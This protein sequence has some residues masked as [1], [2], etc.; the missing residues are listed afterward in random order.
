MAQQYQDMYSNYNSDRSP[1]STRTYGNL[2]LNR[3]SS[4]QFDNY[5]SAQMQQNQLQG[6]YT[7]DDYAAQQHSGPPP[8]FEQRMPASTMHNNGYSPYENQTW[9][10][11]GQS[12]V[13]N[14]MSQTSRVKATRSRA[15]IPS[16]WLP[17]GQQQQLSQ[18]QVSNP[19]GSM[20]QY[21]SQLQGQNRSPPLSA[22]EE[23]IPTA[24]VIKNIP[25]AVKKEQLV[26]LMTDMGLPLPYA[27]NYH[28][29]AGVFRG[30]AFAN[31][32]N[33]DETSTVIQR[34]NHMDLHGRKLRVEYKKML[35][36]QER[37]RI[38]R[39]KREKRGQLQEQ[40]QPLAPSQVQ[41][42]LHTQASMTSLA[43][44]HYPTS[45]PS[46]QQTRDK[47]L[48]FDLNNPT[49]LGYYNELMLFKNSHEDV[50]IFPA[51][52]TPMDRRT[53]H[54]L[55][56]H[57]GLDHR[58]EG[59]GET[60]CVQIL[61][62]GATIS[63]PVPPMPTTYYGNESQRRGLNR[64][65]TIDFSETRD[66]G[67]NYH[68]LSRQGSNLL[69][70]PGSPGMSGLSAAHN[71]RAAKS[72]ADLRSYTPSPVPSTA[73]FPVG[74]TQNISRYTDYG[75]SSAASG[76]PNLTP[77]SA[78]GGMTSRDRDESFLVNGLTNMAIGYDRP[79]ANR[80]NATGRIGQE[81]EAHTSSAGPIG[82]QRPTNGT[83]YDE[84][85]RN[86]ASIV[87]Q[88][89]GPGGDWGAGNGFSRP[90]QNGHV[91]RGSDS[92]DRNGAPSNNRYL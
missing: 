12:S 1:G 50:L 48:D 66:H 40:H 44:N 10:Y 13:P 53:I 69:E 17:L 9:G 52:V 41:N 92:S 72:F 89:N 76:T 90:R 70:L 24:I 51:T 82:S 5:G 59:Q 3:T 20:Q 37:E 58:S 25:F 43:S 74:L 15:Q 19:Y 29:D 45:S 91:N 22:D 85:P 8:R 36:Q 78:G 18:S 2:T 30:L 84:T 88:P 62:R 34:M 42:P 65:A 11:G 4:R 39:D 7:A 57:M 33:A 23:L 61:K 67:S 27:F 16:E 28:F 31:F 73:S 86:G 75:H 79:G 64:A 87:R 55:A 77:T 60:R 14:G 35:P 68:T 32:T 56:H 54:T 63:A 21:G 6:L 81:R 47:P 46:P 26:A 49:T 80:S 83:T 71:L 38:E